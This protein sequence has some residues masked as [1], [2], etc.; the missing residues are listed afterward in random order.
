MSSRGVVLL[1]LRLKRALAPA[2]QRSPV[3]NR[4]LITLYQLFG[5]LQ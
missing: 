1:P 4:I 3:P 2:A 5:A